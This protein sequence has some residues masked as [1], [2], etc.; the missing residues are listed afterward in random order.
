MT[1]VQNVHAFGELKG[2]CTGY[3]GEYNPGKQNLQV[4]AL[5]T[6]WLNANQVMDDVIVAKAEYDIATNYR[7]QAFAQLGKL[8]S[9]IFGILKAGGAS[10]LLLKDAQTLVNKLRGSGSKAHRPPISSQESEP[11]TAKRRLGG[12]D[13]ASRKNHFASLLETVMSEPTYKPNESYLSVAGLQDVL[14]NL[15]KLNEDVVAAKVA[16]REA[17]RNRNILLYEGEE[18]L[19]STALAVKQYVKAIYGFTSQQHTEVFRISFTKP[20]VR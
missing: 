1:H 12:H 20:K 16:L 11:V 14:D 7:E 5:T 2:L 3:G 19:V 4:E 13:Y 9:R 15:R 18:S 6:L 10:P 17:R 8:G